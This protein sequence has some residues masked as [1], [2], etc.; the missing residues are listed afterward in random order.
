MAV[1]DRLL[2]RRVGPSAGRIGRLEALALLV[3]LAV[4]I[5][6]RLAGLGND[7]DVSDEGIRGLQLRLMAAGYRPIAE[8]YASQG[9]L[10]LY[11]FY[12]LYSLF[13]GGIVA[14]RLAVVVYSL[15]GIVGLHWL[16]RRLGGPLARLLAAALL[17]VSPVYLEKSRLAL[18]EVPSLAPAVVALAMLLQHRTTGRRGWLVGS[19]VLLAVAALAKPMAL[20][21]GAAALVLLVSPVRRRDEEAD[22]QAGRWRPRDV[23]LYGLVGAAVSALVV[24]VIGPARVWDQIVGYR[25]AARAVRG[26]DVA[27]N[28]GMVRDEL[29]REGLGLLLAAGIG[30]VVLVRRRP[31]EAGAVLAWLGAG[32]ALLLLYSPLFPKHVVYVLP[33][34]TLLA[35]VGLGEAIGAMLILLRRGCNPSLSR[36]SAASAALLLAVYLA[37]LPLVVGQVGRV[38]AREAGEDAERYADDVQVIAAVAGPNDFIVMD[39]AYLALES[40]RLVPPFLVDLSWNRILARA[41]TAEQAIAETTRFGARAVV[42]QDAH[43]GQLPRYLAWVD[44]EYVLVK[45][46]VQRRPN[47]FRRVYVRPDADLGAARTALVGGIDTPLLADFGPARLLGYSLDRRELKAGG[48]FGLTLHW[49]ALVGSPP[50]HQ[51]VV[52][53]RAADGEPAHEG[54]WRVG[55]AGQVLQTWEAG[56]WMFQNLRILVDDETPPGAYTLSLALVTPNAGPTPI[57]ADIGTWRDAGAELDL[58][59]ITVR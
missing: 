11:L 30:G 38:L 29:G 43:L 34:L 21:A 20:T 6:L 12:P 10:S 16:G 14:A 15:V 19:A 45:S 2:P 55:D 1:A 13:G 44:R 57:R 36:S 25:L 59:P 41:L 22:V 37:G 33:P 3:V 52:R 46:Y 50:E 49:E 58:G 17:A 31:L 5:A 26:W 39:D 42:A 7:T 27:V 28:F 24:G 35:G 56:R 32:F 54:A 18:V 51:M 8:I 53:L 23:A 9:P 48:R 40:G 47:R 4:A